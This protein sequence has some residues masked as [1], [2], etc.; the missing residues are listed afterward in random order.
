MIDEKIL[1]I[2]FSRGLTVGIGFSNGQVC[3]EAAIALASRE[4][5]TDRPSCVSPID[6]KF[7]IGLNDAP[8]SSPE[9]RAEALRPAVL[10]QIGTA[11]TDR[12]PWVRALVLGIIREVLPLALHAVAKVVPDHAAPI[13]AAAERCSAASDL[14]AA[15]EA[16]KT[17]ERV[18]ARTAWAT[19]AARAAN[20]TKMVERAAWAATWAAT[21]TAKT[22]T[23]ATATTA[24]NALSAAAD[25]AAESAW[26]MEAARAERT[27]KAAMAHDNI[28][29]TAIQVGLR[30]YE[31]TA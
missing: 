19:Q 28:L 29:Q 2:Y 8:W 7:W 25:A 20:A 9:A 24:A 3:I 14:A 6:R 26:A 4:P 5:L 13:L 31:Q 23:A 22:A 27:A 18:A 17:A 16:A 11:G 30:A 1:D 21:D 10:P 15:S 12:G